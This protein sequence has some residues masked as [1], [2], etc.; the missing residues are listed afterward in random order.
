MAVFQCK[1]CG[2]MLEAQNNESVVV[3]RSCNAANSVPNWGGEPVQ[4]RQAQPQAPAMEAAPVM[5]APAT[6]APA[7][8]APA[9]EAPVNPYMNQGMEQPQNPYMGQPYGY[10]QA[11]NP[12]MNQGQPYGYQQAPNPYMNQGQPYG[13]PY[14]YQ[15]APNPYMNQ[16][17]PY[18]QPYGY[19]QAPNPYMNQG[20]AP[21]EPI[22]AEAL[23]KEGFEALAMGD[24]R[25]AFEAFNKVQLADPVN[26]EASLGKLMLDL[27]VSD[28]DSISTADVAFDTNPNYQNILRGND[29][30]LKAKLACDLDV[31]HQRLAR[32][33]EEARVDAVYLEAC[34]LM[35]EPTSA[36]F[37]AAIRKFES[38]LGWK[39]SAE[40]LENCA[41]K[42]DGLRQKEAA[43]RAEAARRAEIAR[44]NSKKKKKRILVFGVG[45]AA[46][47]AVV[48]ALVILVFSVFIPN[49]KFNDALALYEEGKLLEAYDVLKEIPGHPK[50]NQLA[51]SISTDVL[52]DFQKY[53]AD[54]GYELTCTDYSE[55]FMTA[56]ELMLVEELTLT[57]ANSLPSS[58]TKR[59]FPNLKTVTVDISGSSSTTMGKVTVKS[60]GFEYRF[61]GNP[62]K[63]YN[64]QLVFENMSYLNLTFKDFKMTYSG[65]ALNLTKVTNADVFFY[66]SCGFQST[67]ASYVA[68]V[69]AKVNMV[70]TN[71]SNVEIKGANGGASANGGT[72]VQ[73]TNLSIAGKNFEQSATLNV[74]G[75]NGGSATSDGGSGGHGSV[76]IK[77][78][79][80]T[81]KGSVSCNITGG[82]GGAGKSGTDKSGLDRPDRPDRTSSGTDGTTGTKGADGGNGGH[83]GNGAAAIDVT[84][85]QIVDATKVKCIGG[86]GG[87][88]GN[89]GAAQNGGHGGHGGHTSKGTDAGDGG[90]GGKGGSG[91][92]GGNGG[93][94]ARAIKIVN[95]N[96]LKACTNLSMTHGYGGNAGSGGA[97]GD[98]G[99]GGNGGDDNNSGGFLGM[100]EGPVEGDGGT[101]GSGGTGGAA[102]TAGSSGSKFNISGVTES[103][104]TNPNKKTASKGADGDS[105]KDGSDGDYGN[106]K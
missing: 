87:N 7:M 93:S 85:L 43:E 84:S 13:Q 104:A 73:V 41:G 30:E 50:A 64:M 98:G 65:T 77:A 20:M 42:L 32:A 60:E 61:V 70:L 95:V 26:T 81:I 11:P 27:R 47:V 67:N 54:N 91:G 33:A 82:S 38:I 5:E 45:G 101:K 55:E 71:N 105:G 23:V 80:L 15:Q 36:N 89:G 24:G 68:F 99:N 51:I 4:P 83:G 57:S 90:T 74:Y 6:A 97:A 76:G 14:G 31:I 40:R 12:Y 25:R 88:A 100:G 17:Q 96:D 34:Q 66:G 1:A 78:T 53:L 79:S 21:Q 75:G 37:E 29:E 92:T 10:Q 39:D 46:V 8:E 2:A 28:K 106:S 44:A 48:V 86:N 18:G 22:D 35:S 16:G 63:T 62:S 58:A 103:V 52:A 3:C 94:G 102:G 9:M 49:A 19:Q 59:I 56:S 72:A 69:G